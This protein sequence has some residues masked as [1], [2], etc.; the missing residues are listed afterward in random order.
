[1]KIQTLTFF[2]HQ[3]STRRIG[4]PRSFDSL[5]NNGKEKESGEYSRWEMNEIQFA[6]NFKY[7]EG[8]GVY[9]DF[10]L[11]LSSKMENGK[12]AWFF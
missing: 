7:Q 10:F 12:V 6:L 8:R 11:V 1:M 4:H 2:L 5:E 9:S 3:Q